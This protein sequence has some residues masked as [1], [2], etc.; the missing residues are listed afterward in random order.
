MDSSTIAYK[1]DPAGLLF[2][3]I[4]FFPEKFAVAA[5]VIK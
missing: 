4:D 5:T 2:C 1:L 3:A